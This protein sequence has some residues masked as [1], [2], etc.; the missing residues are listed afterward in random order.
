MKEHDFV[1]HLSDLPSRHAG[2]LFE[3]LNQAALS[4]AFY[5]RAVGLRLPGCPDVPTHSEIYDHLCRLTNFALSSY[6]QAQEMAPKN[7]KANEI[8]GEEEDALFS[9]AITGVSDVDGNGYTV[10]VDF[11]L[12]YR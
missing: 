9:I 1:G 5:M 6:Y 8:W 3:Q 2:F 4:A 10:S 12:L 11:N 7:Q